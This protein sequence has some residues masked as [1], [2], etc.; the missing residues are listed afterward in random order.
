MSGFSLRL[1]AFAR[2]R[3]C[4]SKQCREQSAGP[5]NPSKRDTIMANTPHPTDIKL[6]KQSGVLE[7]TWDTGE[8]F[9]YTAEYLRVNSPSAEV[10]GHGPG[11][12]VLQLGKEDVKIDTI[13]AV[14]NYALCPYFDD[15]HSTG[16]YAW[17]TL[18][19]LGKDHDQLWATY[20][21]RCE[22]AGYKRKTPAN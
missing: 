8:T 5:D 12:E 19:R 6:H 7:I 9:N 3:F 21:K 17:D 14:G 11:E 22:E 10:Q 2:D 20:L 13:E 1:G 15:N 18:Y 16:I 4:F